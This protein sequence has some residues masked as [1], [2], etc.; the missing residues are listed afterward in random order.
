MRIVYTSACYIWSVA[1]WI[2]S[3]VIVT[4][5]VGVAINLFSGSKANLAGSVFTAIKD[6]FNPPLHFAQILTLTLIILCIVTTLASVLICALLRKRFVVPPP[7]NPPPEIKAMLE[8]LEQDAKER[9]EKQ[10]AQRQR[11][12]LALTHYL[13]SI[14]EANRSLTPQGFSLHVPHAPALIFADVPLE[15]VFVP[16]HAFSDRPLFDAPY[17][18]LRLLGALRQRTD[19]SEE[20]RTAYLQGIHAAWHSQ[21]GAQSHQRT[22]QILPVSEVLRQLAPQHPVAVILGEPGSGKSTLLQWLALHMATVS[23]APSQALPDGFL[24]AQV[25]FL[26]RLHDYAAG[27]NKDAHTL[28]QF[29]VA[30]A[31]QIHPNAPPRLLDELARGHCFVL[32]DGLDEVANARTRRAVTDAVSAFIAEYTGVGS[33]TH[34]YNR[35]L[36]TSRIAGYEPRALARYAHYTLLELDDQQIGQLL[37]NWY[38]A[39][40]CYLAMSA[41]GMQDLT[42]EERTAAHTAGAA[43]RDQ[44]LRMLQ[45]SPGLRQLASNPL[46]LTMM[47]ILQ[48]SGR[49][50]P[51]HRLELCQMLTRTLLDTWNQESGRAMFSAGEL[52]LAELLL[53]T[54]A[55]RLHNHA[56]ALA[57]SEVVAIT[58][59]TMAEFYGQQAQEITEDTIL[60]FIETLRSSSGLFVEVGEQLFCFAHSTFQDYF[61]AQYLLRKPREELKQFALEHGQ[62]D[63]W[64]EPLLLLDAVKS[65]E[66]AEKSEVG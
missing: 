16:L 11:D 32:F 3:A 52:P 1:K 31:S 25:P 61:V 35:F 60:Q 23:L 24:P 55:Y 5:L 33:E 51:A 28:K 57:A 58:R 9:K 21:L 27:L 26:I 19:L 17:E 43:Q 10:T 36:I 42:E 20:T 44:C 45:S 56:P 6:W 46:A 64:R 13:R 62:Q 30:Q 65:M 15:A 8:Y 39:I 63:A 7:Y 12:D 54:F 50:L 59:Q 49:T 66:S 14:R 18:Q 40:E 41:R 29:V 2:W 34:Q 53:S 38:T 48:A 22:R 47:A 4:I 37:L